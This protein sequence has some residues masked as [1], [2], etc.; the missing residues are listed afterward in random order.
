MS[1]FIRAKAIEVGLNQ[2][3]NCGRIIN[4]S[5]YRRLPEN[6]Q[7]VYRTI[8]EVD[9]V[10]LI[11]KKVTGKTEYGRIKLNTQFIGQ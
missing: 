10:P 3:F 1:R 4:E 7:W 2:T 5:S 8:S 11:T 9:A 6:A